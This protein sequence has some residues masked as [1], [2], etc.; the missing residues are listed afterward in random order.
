MDE[1]PSKNEAYFHSLNCVDVFIDE[2]GDTTVRPSPPEQLERLKD[3]RDRLQAALAAGV[4]LTEQDVRW[5]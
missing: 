1:K 4:D 2:P 5:E 3:L